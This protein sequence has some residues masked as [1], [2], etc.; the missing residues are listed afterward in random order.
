MCI[1][2]T[3]EKDEL[4]A[5]RATDNSA[6]S[7]YTE[8]SSIPTISAM[9]IAFGNVS[10]ASVSGCVI[11]ITEEDLDY[12]TSLSLEEVTQLKTQIMEQWGFKTDDDYKKILEEIEEN[13]CANINSEEVVKVNEFVFAYIDMPEG[14]KSIKALET[15]TLKANSVKVSQACKQCCAEAA[16][17]ID[18]FGRKLIDAT[19]TTSTEQSKVT[20]SQ[21]KK[22]FGIRI[23]LASCSLVW[24][25]CLGSFLP[26]PGW[27]GTYLAGAAAYAE[28]VDAW[29]NYMLCIRAA[30]R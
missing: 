22:H 25:C 23:A 19:V 27:V 15:Q 13:V 14:A 10:R 8:L 17:G 11:G 16:L 1:S 26:G 9:N 4:V 6:L 12:L 24:G 20:E 28:T 21:C 30:R 7:I 2:C 29:A 5:I 18:R 3:S